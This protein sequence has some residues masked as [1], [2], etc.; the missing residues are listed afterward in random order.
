MNILI[1]EDD[2]ISRKLLVTN[3]EQQGYSVSV[4]RDGAEA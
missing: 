3:L 4:A 1:A 2:F